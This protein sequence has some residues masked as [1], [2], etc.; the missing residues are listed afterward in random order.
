MLVIVMI[1][2]YEYLFDD[3]Y[4]KLLTEQNFKKI[5]D[6]CDAFFGGKGGGVGEIDVTSF[7][8]VGQNILNWR[9]LRLEEESV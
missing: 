2:V 9:G 3:I 1:T 7:L 5:L 8:K 6:C 4:L